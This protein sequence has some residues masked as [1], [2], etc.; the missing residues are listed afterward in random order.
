M[1][2]K[3]FN[4]SINASVQFNTKKTV[5]LCKYQYMYTSAFQKVEQ[6]TPSFLKFVLSI[7]TKKLV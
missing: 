1:L 5:L 7:K 4:L 3:K 2:H 6:K